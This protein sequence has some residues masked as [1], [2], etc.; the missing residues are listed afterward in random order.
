MYYNNLVLNGYQTVRP[1]ISSIFDHLEQSKRALLLTKFAKSVQIVGKYRKSP[2]MPNTFKF[3]SKGW[4][5]AKSGHT[6][7]SYKVILPPCDEWSQTKS[8]K[9]KNDK[10][11]EILKP[12]LFPIL[13]DSFP[14]KEEWFHF[15]R[16][17]LNRRIDGFCD[18]VFEN[19][20]KVG[21]IKTTFQRW[22]RDKE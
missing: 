7:T 3:L 16:N 20:F 13:T 21:N 22:R 17:I 15:G 4:N 14:P 6:D 2:K 10:N 18:F 8:E 11:N 1:I 5:F 12:K 9:I 19:N